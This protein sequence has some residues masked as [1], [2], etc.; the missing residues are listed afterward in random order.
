MIQS[1]SEIQKGWAGRVDGC[2]GGYTEMLIQGATGG[3]V[4]ERKSTTRR[5]NPGMDR[6][7]IR[8][9]QVRWLKWEWTVGGAGVATGHAAFRWLAVLKARWRIAAW[10]TAKLREAQEKRRREQTR[11]EFRT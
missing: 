10:D 2:S 6:Y 8:T 1:T 5:E 3:K 9:E 7:T 11:R 4:V